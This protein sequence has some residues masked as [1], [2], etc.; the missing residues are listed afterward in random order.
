MKK[1]VFQT[2]E[3]EVVCCKD[4]IKYS[5]IGLLSTY[6]AQRKGGVQHVQCIKL[7]GFGYGKCS[8]LLHMQMVR[9]EP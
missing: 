7:P 5:I 1:A 8:W 2:Q 4:I 3:K 9:P 6:T